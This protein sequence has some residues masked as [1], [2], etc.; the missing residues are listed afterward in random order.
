MFSFALKNDSMQNE[1]IFCIETKNKFSFYLEKRSIAKR[2]YFLCRNFFLDFALKKAPI[3]NESVLCVENRNK[4]SFYL[5]K[6]SMHPCK[7]KVFFVSKIK[8]N[9]VFALKNAPI[10]D[11]QFFFVIF[12]FSS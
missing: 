10:Q 8:I 11:F 1:S 4:F 3:Q 2:K 9:L 12:N 5:E 7:T 6:H